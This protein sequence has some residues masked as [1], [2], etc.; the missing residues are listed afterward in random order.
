MF[1]NYRIIENV[2]FNIYYNKTTVWPFFRR[3]Y[4]KDQSNIDIW[5]WTSTPSCWACPFIQ[6]QGK[7]FVKQTADNLSLKSFS[8]FQ[9]MLSTVAPR[10]SSRSGSWQNLVFFANT[11][12]HR[13]LIISE[14]MQKYD[15]IWIQ[16]VFTFFFISEL[17]SFNP[18]NVLWHLFFLTNISQGNLKWRKLVKLVVDSTCF[19]LFFKGFCI[20]FRVV[21]GYTWCC[22]V[23]TLVGS[24][25]NHW[26]KKSFMGFLLLAK[27]LNL[28]ETQ[29]LI[30]NLMWFEW[31][32]EFDLSSIY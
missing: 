8:A 3:I 10:Q 28:H 22:M 1:E 19:L 20:Y 24:N 14:N 21:H 26:S 4:T 27:Q 18:L 30:S 25:K 9:S 12:T 5:T 13:S 29:N 17:W 15:N 32:L 2:S 6:I 31:T 11:N 16:I 23:L 7:K